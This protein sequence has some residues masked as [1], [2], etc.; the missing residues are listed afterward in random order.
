MDF[1]RTYWVKARLQDYLRASNGNMAITLGL[2][3][4]PLILAYGVAVDYSRQLTLKTQFDSI[5]DA[6]ALQAVDFS[7]MNETIAQAQA[8][9]A[10]QFTALAQANGAAT[11][12]SV[13]INLSTDTTGRVSS[14][15]YSVSV[16]PSTTGMLGFSKLS[17]GG[18]A[19]A[20]SAA[21]T[22][23]DI[24]V[25]ADNTPSMGI[26]ATASDIATMQSLTTNATTAAGF[27]GSCAFACHI[28]GASYDYYSIAR[29]N[30]VTLRIDSVRNAVNSLLATAQA[31]TT[32][33]VS[34]RFAM[35]TFG[36]DATNETLTNIYALSSDLTGAQSATSAINLMSIPY[37]GYANDTITNY[38]LIFNQLSST[39]PNSGNGQ[40]QALSRKLVFFVSDGMEDA[41]TGT[42][43]Q[44]VLG[45][46]RCQAPIDSSLCDNLKSRG[47]TIAAI[48]TTYL[49]I[50]SNSW[51][52]STVQPFNQGPFSP[53]PNSK[54]AQAMKACASTGY[55]QEVGPTDSIAATLNLLFNQFVMQSARI[56]G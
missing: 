27:S 19:T 24:Y 17:V 1:I 47:I 23:L 13:T 42:C 39:I 36:A 29:S 31:A 26:G 9:A 35:Y 30:G 20:H 48:Y 7:A 46:P 8:D 51:Y 38:P 16:P 12:D 52:V 49:P 28:S 10:K 21:P 44:P 14:V 55:Y 22:Y 45:G 25:L 11:V 3:A 41:A 15:S 53:S 18:T 34:F 33:F 6:V 5:A 54:V 50:P 32:P 56:T 43:S 37:Q 4:L 2:C 40:T